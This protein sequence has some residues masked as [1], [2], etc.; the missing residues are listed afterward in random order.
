DDLQLLDPEGVPDLVEERPLRDR[1]LDAALPVRLVQHG[2]DLRDDRLLDRD[3][4]AIAEREHG[5]EMQCGTLARHHGADYE[6]RGAGGEEVLGEDA[7]RA[8]VRP[9]ALADEKDAVADRHDVT[10]LEG[11]A[12][13]VVVDAAEPDRELGAAEAWVEAVDRLDIQS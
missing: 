10:A 12:A 8:T 2:Q 5:V 1:G 3:E 9:L 4:V 6:S 13:P 7:H 11:G